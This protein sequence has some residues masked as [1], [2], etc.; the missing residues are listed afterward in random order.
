MF[1]ATIFYGYIGVR[2]DFNGKCFRFYNTF[3]ENWWFCLI[4]GY[5]GC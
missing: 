2:L 5:F 1:F 4:F 3:S